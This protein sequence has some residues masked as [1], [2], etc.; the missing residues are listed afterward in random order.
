MVQRN[1]ELSPRRVGHFA[2]QTIEISAG[3]RHTPLYHFAAHKPEELVQRRRQ[4][5]I[6]RIPATA[7]PAMLR[8]LGLLRPGRRHH[9]FRLVRAGTADPAAFA[10]RSGGKLTCMSYAP[11]HGEQAPFTPNLRI[12]DRQIERTCGGFPP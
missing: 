4:A 9:R 12:P 2:D 5:A 1:M 11:F 3:R 8:S 10:A 6:R 7:A